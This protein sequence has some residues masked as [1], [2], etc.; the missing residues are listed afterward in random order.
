MERGTERSSG[1]RLGN[2]KALWIVLLSVLMGVT[3]PAGCATREVAV[4]AADN[5]REVTLKRGQTLAVALEANPTTGYDWLLVVEPP[6][7]ILSVVGEEFAAPS[8]DRG[9]A[10]GVTTWRFRAVGEGETGLELGY[11]RS[12]EEGMEPLET[13]RIQVAVR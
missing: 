11:A 2:M 6:L 9:G 12:W 10:G 1:V 8:G 4:G 5:G 13:F 7:E 3:L